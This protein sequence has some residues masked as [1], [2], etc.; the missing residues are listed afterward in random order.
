MYL[1]SQGA[2]L[3]SS[4]S[5]YP[6]IDISFKRIADSA[7]DL[8]Q[9]V[10]SDGAVLYVN[11]AWRARLDYSNDTIFNFSIADLLP[12]HGQYS[13]KSLFMTPSTSADPVEATLVGRSGEH[14]RVE[15]TI[16]VTEGDNGDS[17]YVGILREPASREPLYARLVAAYRA[18]PILIAIVTGD[19]AIIEA[20]PAWET[21]LS[22]PAG[23]MV[24]SHLDNLTEGRSL[25]LMT[26]LVGGALHAKESPSTTIALLA[27]DGALHYFDCTASPTANHG[28][29]LFLGLHADAPVRT[30]VALR[31]T[32]EHFRALFHS[33][34]VPIS[35]SDVSGRVLDA[36]KAVEAVFGYTVEEI[37]AGDGNL[38]VHPDWV[39]QVRD[40]YRAGVE[41]GTAG[42]SLS[43]EPYVSLCRA[44]DGRDLWIS[45]S[46][47]VFLDSSDGSVYLINVFQ[48]VTEHRRL[49]K[50]I[51]DREQRFRLLFDHTPIGVVMEDA[52]R[53]IAAANPAYHALLGY[54]QG[55][56]IGRTF[57]LFRMPATESDGPGLFQQ[58]ESGATVARAVRQYRKKD[59]NPISVSVTA[60]AIRDEN[61]ALSYTIGT[62]QDM[63]A[64]RWAER[65]TTI[66]LRRFRSV[67]DS[68]PLGIAVLGIDTTVISINLALAEMVGY[69]P[70]DLVGT[71]LKSLVDPRT[72]LSNR[73]LFESLMAGEIETFT[74]DMALRTSSGEVIQTES[75]VAPLPDEQGKPVGAI[76]M[77]QDVTQ[78][79]QT[80]AELADREQLFRNIFE[81]SPLG[82]ALIAPDETIMSANNA[83][84]MMLGYSGA[85]LIGLTMEGLRPASVPAT[86]SELHERMIAGEAAEQQNE[87]P[88]Q[89]KDGSEF[90]GRST[91]APVR[92]EEGILLYSIRILED[93]DEQH[94]TQR[95][96][97]EF[98]AIVGHELRTP[99]TSINAVL[100][101][102]AEGSLG[103]LAPRAQDL[104]T[105]A[106]DNS[107]RLR[108][109]VD[110]LL[111][112][113]RL[114]AS[115]APLKIVSST[116][117]APVDQAGRIAGVGVHALMQRDYPS[118]LAI[119]MDVDRVAQ[120]LA[121]LF[122][123]AIKF[124]S[125]GA[126][127]GLQAVA[128]GDG[129]A[130]ISVT[131]HG[132][133]IPTDQLPRI[134]E[135]FYQVDS[136]DARHA[137]GTGIG[138]AIAKQLVEA[139]GG[140]I[141]VKSKRG[142]GSVFT[143]TLPL[144]TSE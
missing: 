84:E 67:F 90:I 87:R 14:V 27:H 113:D 31:R 74:L 139:H 21:L 43:A 36:N 25:H 54:D 28:E 70:G 103:A 108:R 80:A 110:D 141:W 101:L 42:S 66:Q 17:V 107:N 62:L 115:R 47:D 111:D 93:V 86:N 124:S 10:G 97:D 49:L 59:G 144:A 55:E 1:D 33:V 9:V 77:I 64:Q 69:E 102:L 132:Q 125:V 45:T 137:G 46:T 8:I 23:A 126:P 65:Q 140:Q 52:H 98:L 24:G 40:R 119:A 121:N 143:F 7:V 30:D 134:F 130:R 131:D 3:R 50:E 39:E 133:G 32:Q 129:F 38:W 37:R 44:K 26:E 94:R 85:E 13:S 88:Y 100:G 29:V 16:T 68:A 135:R 136:S 109:L 73:G 105:L 117:D 127:I 72:G 96:K 128:S 48:D 118:D 112:L 91:W 82:I 75:V 120:I 19:G 53:I 114:A 142:E 138:L 58:L 34:P 81:H 12:V 123:N 22:Y 41:A 83:M 4:Y 78:Q 79:R 57:E 63:S 116:L 71:S 61:G 104:L 106:Q 5:T 92:D 18:A 95:L 56:L 99:L 20:N 15:G 60:T 6:L 89:R 76:R 122:A 11:P 35:L 2:W 51:S